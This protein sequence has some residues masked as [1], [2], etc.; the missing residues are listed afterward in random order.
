MTHYTRASAEPQ[1][2][3]PTQYSAQCSVLLHNTRHKVY[4][5]ITHKHTLH[6]ANYQETWGPV[7]AGL[8]TSASVHSI[9]IPTL[10][11]GVNC[12]TVPLRHAISQS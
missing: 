5:H 11:C 12:D 7:L 1:Y 10:N 8:G 4:T 3:V 6:T 2:S 9:N